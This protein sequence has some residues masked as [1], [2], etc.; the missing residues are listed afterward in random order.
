LKSRVLT[1]VVALVLAVLGTGGV[2]VYVHGA[3]SRA[4]AGMKAVTVLVAQ[5]RIPGGTSAADAQQAGLL[6]SETLPAKSVPQN[7]LKSLSAGL[8]SLVMSTDVQPG[9]VLLRPMLVT[10]AEVKSGLAIPQGMVAV[11]I[12]VCLVQAV[13]GNIQAGSDVAVF[14]TVATKSIHIQ[15]DCG[16]NHQSQTVG[17]VYTRNV[18]PRA[19]VVAV[20]AAASQQATQTGIGQ[21]A[22]NNASGQ[23]GQNGATMVT[24]AVSQADAERLITLQQASLPYLALLTTTSQSHYDTTRVPLFLP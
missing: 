14:T 8:G 12:Q 20:G 21:A 7:A 17:A 13:A 16:G 24:L 6:G 3:D 11:S 22:S 15:Q 18:I 4:V 9:Q 2:L 23:G 5:Q 10:A 19:V 1:I